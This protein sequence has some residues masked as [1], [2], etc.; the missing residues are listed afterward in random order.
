MAVAG[1]ALTALAFSPALHYP[2]LS[3]AAYAFFS[4]ICHQDPARSFWIFG[5]PLAVCARC[6]G[7]YAGALG[8][9][10]VRTDRRTAA[11][12][13]LLAVVLN[14]ADVVTEFAGF[15]GN[16]MPARFLLGFALG[17][18]I[19]GV[20]IASD[21]KMWIDTGGRVTGGMVYPAR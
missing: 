6:L 9:A 20:L 14:A 18:A 8:G 1:L 19:T 13:L 3:A 11:T 7:I 5:A 2:L 10:R 4:H 16:L 21:K 15:H 17:A 12:A